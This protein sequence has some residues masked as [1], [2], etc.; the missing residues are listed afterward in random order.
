MD[1]YHLFKLSVQSALIGVIT[2]KLF[3]VSCELRRSHIV[4]ETYFDGGVLEEDEDL[5]RSISH[6][7]LADFPDGYTAEY[8]CYSVRDVQ[9]RMLDFWAFLRSERRAKRKVSLAA[10][11]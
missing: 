4:I 2:D 7:V 11:A 5:A 10:S 3:A 8:R 6:E 9:P 1:D